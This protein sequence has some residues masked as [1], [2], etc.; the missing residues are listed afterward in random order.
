MRTVKSGLKGL[1]TTEKVAHART[2]VTGLTGNPAFSTP[3]P[4]LAVV[5]AAAD[6]TETA[7][8]NALIGGPAERELRRVAE[9]ELDSVLAHLCLYV[10]TTAAGD[11]AVAVTSNFPLIKQPT[12]VGKLPAPANAHARLTDFAGVVDLKWDAVANARYYHAYICSTDPSVEANWSLVG[13]SSR[14][15]HTV[16]D[17]KGGQFYWFRITAVGTEG[18]GAAS[19]VVMKRAA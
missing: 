15:A 4:A 13:I 12:P 2:V 1:R 7:Y 9:A 17:L 11:P 5:T 14:A 6:K 3:T 19:D 8:N 16:T 10:N 18:E